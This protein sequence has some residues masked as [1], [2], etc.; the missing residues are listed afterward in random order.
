MKKIFEMFG[1]LLFTGFSFFYT[2][3]VSNIIKSKDPIMLKINNIKDSNTKEVI[4]PVINNDEYIT[5][6][7]GCEIDVKKSYEKM[8]NYGEFKNELLVMKEVENRE[9]KDKYIVGGNKLE[10]KVSFLF[11]IRDN[12]DENIMNY[13][14]NK[15]IKVNYFI[16]QDFLENNTLLIKFMSKE[17]NIYYLGKDS[18]YIDRYMLFANNL[19]QSNSS[20]M[21]N[22]CILE[23]KND[24]Y[25][26]VC[27][28]YNMKTIKTD[29]I[30]NDIFDNVK[31]TLKNGAI[32][33]IDSNDY[34]KIK[35][36]LNYAL[37]RGYNIVSLDELL[38]QN[39]KCKQ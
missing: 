31:K 9:I 2:E 33:A 15:N 35:L 37:S 12:I 14:K 39:N 1:I 26:R 36:S 19:I 25:L 3:K 8:K 24:E 32:I 13:I 23:D 34:E 30:K 21:P 7:N 27:S 28:D 29:Y 18:K 22:Y 20:N 4:K 6:L 11:I 5:G 38:S 10:K 16:D 17:S